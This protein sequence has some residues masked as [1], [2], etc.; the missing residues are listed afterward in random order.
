MSDPMNQRI[1]P[2][3]WNSHW[4][5]AAALLLGAAAGAGL[6]V[7]SGLPEGDA[8]QRFAETGIALAD[9]IAEV[10]LQL[11]KMLVAPLILFS[12]MAGLAQIADPKSLGRL[13]LRTFVYYIATSLLAV[14]T[15]LLLVN[16]VRPGVGAELSLDVSPEGLPT[17]PVS[18]TGIFVRMFTDNI[19]DSLARGDVLQIIVF[20]LLAG[21]AATRLSGRAK[22]SVSRIVS[23][24]FELM[25]GLAHIVL[26][27]LPIAVFALVARV[28]AR[29]AGGEFKPLLLYAMTVVIGLAFHAL[30]VLPIIFRLTTGISPRVWARAMAPA[31]RLKSFMFS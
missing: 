9:G 14:L 30:V 25:T 26:A 6:N 15:G 11:L 24:G 23:A 13:G 22:K 2:A 29:S 4:T 12:I 18:L 10:F 7:A 27:T 16:L 8:L 17:E 1:G 5:V 31:A 28:A 3:W 19:F 20:A 21:V